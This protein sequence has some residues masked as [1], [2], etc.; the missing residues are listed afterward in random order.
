V[1]SEEIK[2]RRVQKSLAEAGLV[3]VDLDEFPER[4]KEVKHLA[5]GRLGE[6]LERENAV[7]ERQSVAHSLGTL[8]RLETTLRAD[9]GLPKSE[10]SRPT[11]E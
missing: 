7:Q 11:D 8:K 5:I 1:S 4:I 6:L 10:P 2:T 9:P 3:D